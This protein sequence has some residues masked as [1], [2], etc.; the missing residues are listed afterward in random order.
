MAELNLQLGRRTPQGRV[1]AA[2]VTAPRL[3]MSWEDWLTLVPALVAYLAIAYSLQQANWVDNMPPLIPTTIGGLVVG[4][5]AARVR[6]PA[7]GIHP[8]ALAVGAGVVLLSVQSY[9]EGATIADRLADVRIRLWEWYHV[10]RAG[11]VSNDNLPFVTAVH[12]LTFLAAYLAAW[13]IYRWHTPWLAVIPGGIGLAVNIATLDG[14]P[15]GPFLVFLFGA[16]LL[17]ARLH[18]QGRQRDWKQ[19]RTEY[20]ELISLETLRLTT[21]VGLVLL[22]GAWL[23]PLGKQ[24]SVAEAVAD[25]LVSPISSRTEDLALRLFHDIRVNRGGNFHK[26]GDTMPIRGDV[27]LGTRVLYT[28]EVEQPGFL[29]GASYDEYTGTGWKS[30]DRE[31]TRVEPGVLPTQDVPGASYAS[32][33]TVVV[34]VTVF[35]DEPILFSFG[36]PLGADVAASVETPELYEGDIERLRPQ[37]GLSE[38]DRYTVAGSVSVATP[39]MLQGAGTNYPEWVRERYLQLPDDLPERVRALAAE[40]TAGAPTQYDKAIAIEEFLR[41]LPFDYAVPA[42]PAGED[43]ADYFLFELQRGY[44]DYFSTAM[45][46]MLRTV[47]VPA[48]VATGYWLDPA[49]FENGAFTVRKQHAYSWVEVFFPGYGWVEFNPSPD[50]PGRSGGGLGAG[51]D[52]TPLNPGEDIANIPLEELI[53]PDLFNIEVDPGLQGGGTASLNGEPAGPPWTLIWTLAGL[54][55]AALVAALAAQ[56]AWNWPVRGL[57]G[58]SRLWAKTQRLGA[59]AGLPPDER[60]TPREWS[61]RVGEALEQPEDAL[62]LAAA[63]EEARYGRPDLRRYDEEE[64]Q[65][66]YVTLRNALVAR[67]FRRGQR[68]RREADA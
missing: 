5:I 44:F 22:I 39:E 51:G 49:E 56:A 31:R 25:K 48:R 62:R 66:A 8:V 19:H 59:W 68:R 41:T 26:F 38:G 11:D 3:L 24:A 12:G 61:R 9:A 6:F 46:V 67:I 63:Y 17:I 7:Y 20:P 21:A 36:I 18:L 16:L 53:P 54:L 55:T 1:A 28:A 30:T 43:V 42:T 2:A 27:N 29:R 45:A 47:G 65:R 40:V 64:A 50:R 14:R 60:A 35:D 37:E 4:L 15:S 10:V 13:S 52:R 23:V 57:E 32:R 34:P 33:V 58:V